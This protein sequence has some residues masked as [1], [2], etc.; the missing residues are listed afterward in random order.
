VILKAGFGVLLGVV[1][2]GKVPVTVGAPG[3]PNKDVSLLIA[4]V[5]V[6]KVADNVSSIGF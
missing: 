2:K 5:P 3:V 4:A 6:P 1:V